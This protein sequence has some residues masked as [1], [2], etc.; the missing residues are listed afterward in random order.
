MKSKEVF[1]VS[2]RSEQLAK[3]AYERCIGCKACMK[4]SPMLPQFCENPKDLF[5]ALYEKGL[6]EKALPYS[7]MLCNYC[8]AVCPK[9]IDIKAIMLSL[10]EDACAELDEKLPKEWN[11]GGVELHQ[12]LSFSS[13]MHRKPDGECDTVFFP[14]CGLQAYSP[15]L[16]R[17][18]RTFL[19]ERLGG[20]GFYNACCGKPTYY[21]GQAQSFEGYYEKLRKEF[22]TGGIRRVITGCQNCF[23]TL[24]TMSPELE[25]RS[26]YEVLAEHATPD[27]F[28]GRNA[29]F[30]HAITLHDPCPTR[31]E[32]TIHE[33]V[34]SLLSR[35]GF[36]WEELP[37]N[38]KRT[39]CCGAG[40]VV[41]LT[42]PEIARAHTKRRADSAT[43]EMVVTYC[44]EC[45]E[46]MRS[47]GKEAVH[48]LD[49]LFDDDPM[50]IKQEHTSLGKKWTNRLKVRF[51]G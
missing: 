27:D 1:S 11:L 5:F 17:R 24:G 8:L 47:G 50:R 7:C 14:G 10:R 33:G 16:V 26:L 9:G 40:A 6:F 18:V 15:E 45:V 32:P 29:V 38:R 4:G 46:S 2:K 31:F 28:V 35:M 22:K 20:C 44:Q 42:E 37:E 25:V 19:D 34:R 51:Y 48:I 49:L 39:L 43:T 13:L 12:R 21:T 30:S 23:I 36:E 3:S 41:S